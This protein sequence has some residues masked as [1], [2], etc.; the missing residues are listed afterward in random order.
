MAGILHSI[1]VRVWTKYQDGN[2]NLKVVLVDKL[3]QG[4]G[5]EL[6]L[7]IYSR[8]SGKIE[9]SKTIKKLKWTANEEIVIP[10]KNLPF[11]CSHI[12]GTFVD[13]S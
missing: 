9:R 12:Q 3:I 1:K 6:T 4:K 10:I 5:G 8:V 2:L 11:G 13:D 7:D